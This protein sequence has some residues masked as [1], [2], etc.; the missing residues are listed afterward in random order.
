MIRA[1]MSLPAFFMP[2]VAEDLFCQRWTRLLRTILR[3][4]RDK[5]NVFVFADPGLTFVHQ[6]ISVSFSRTDQW[7]LKLSYFQ[8]S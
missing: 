2:R 1:V 8:I 7:S 5:H 6:R 3:I 4:I